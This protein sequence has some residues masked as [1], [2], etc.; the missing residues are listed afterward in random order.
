[1]ADFKLDTSGERWL[2]VVGY[3][4]VYEVSDLGRVRSIDRTIQRAGRAVRVQ[5]VMLSLKV[6]RSGYVYVNVSN[7]AKPAAL[8]VHRLVAK[9]F[10]PNQDGL[11]IVNHRDCDTQHN[12]LGN[13]EWCSA[14]HHMRHAIENERFGTQRLS[15]V[16][17]LEIRAAYSA[18]LRRTDIADA[19]NIGVRHVWRIGTRRAYAHLVGAQ[20]YAS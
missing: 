19:Y 3:E 12:A 15:V 8:L 16:D 13:L 5:G 2:P 7:E 10:L 14:E 4:G 11:P 6:N 17:V 20:S 18:G 1:M 9:A